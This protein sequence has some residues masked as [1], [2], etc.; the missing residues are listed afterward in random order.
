MN[1][2]KLKQF[3]VGTPYY[4]KIN[5]SIFKKY[6]SF[7]NNA[8]ITFVSKG[9]IDYKILVE[10]IFPLIK[11]KN[12]LLISLKE[13]QYK[14]LS[15]EY[16]NDNKLEFL[17]KHPKDF[18]SLFD[19]YI[20]YHAGYFDPHPR[21]FHECIFYNKKIIYI[22]KENIKD[23]GY[24]RYKDAMENG[25]KNVWLDENDEIVKEIIK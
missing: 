7:E 21:L 23:G 4:Q 9:I 25:L 19:T 20:Y 2:N 12:K 16:K 8:F 10:E 17:L 5:F 15:Q 11:T 22:N 13:D 1:K 14:Q 3:M 18:H 24:F 6:D